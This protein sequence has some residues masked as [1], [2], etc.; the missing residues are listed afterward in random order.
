[1][2]PG[3]SDFRVLRIKRLAQELF[4][5]AATINDI[6]KV[7]LDILHAST[8]TVW[9]GYRR[10]VRKIGAQTKNVSEAVCARYFTYVRQKD[11]WIAMLVQVCYGAW[12]MGTNRS[13]RG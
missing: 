8:L 2:P 3:L 11:I 9:H 6:L 4:S 13:L 1:M 10:D 7:L 12:M 5:C